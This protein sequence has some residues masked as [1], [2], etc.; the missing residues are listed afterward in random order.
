MAAATRSSMLL[1]KVWP[2]VKKNAAKIKVKKMVL[3]TN[4]NMVRF[5]EL[6]FLILL[7]KDLFHSILRNRN[8]FLHMILK[9]SARQGISF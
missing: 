7:T 9:G 1:G 6:S 5:C 4:L 3:D 8:I 2:S